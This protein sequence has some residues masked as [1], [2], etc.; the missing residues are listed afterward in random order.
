MMPL[1]L[2]LALAPADL[3]TVDIQGD[4]DFLSIQAAVDGAA[5]GDTI[6]VHVPDDP[7]Q[8]LAGFRITGKSLTVSSV[9]GAPV[10]D[11]LYPEARQL[12]GPVSIQGLGQDQVVVLTGLHFNAPSSLVGNG[13]HAPGL[14]VT[15]CAGSVRVEDC[16]IRGPKASQALV[17][18]L[19]AVS[20]LDLTVVDCIVAG[21]WQGGGTSGGAIRLSASRA[22]FYQSTIDGFDGLTVTGYDGLIRGGDGGFGIVL[23]ER[24]FAWIG[25]C[26]VRGG[27]GGRA[28]CHI[29]CDTEGGDGGVGVDCQPASVCMILD[30]PVAGGAGGAAGGGGTNVPGQDASSTQGLPFLVPGAQRRMEVPGTVRGNELATVRIVGVPGERATIQIGTLGGLRFLGW[31]W[32]VYLQRTPLAA[33]IVDL[34]IIPASGEITGSVS[35]PSVGDDE[36][37]TF[38]LQGVCRAVPNR[39][40]LTPVV[41][42][43]VHGEGLPSILPGERVYVDS[44]S[45]PGGNG[46]SWQLARSNLRAALRAAPVGPAEDPVEIWIREGRY[47]AAAPGGSVDAFFPLRDG[48]DLYGGFAGDELSLGERSPREHVTLIDADLNGDDTASGNRD[49][50]ATSLFVAGL[51]FDEQAY[52]DSVRL[53][54]MTLRGTREGPAVALS[55]SAVFH[56]VIFH[57]NH[58][59][60]NADAGAICH[61][62]VPTPLHQQTRIVVSRCMFAGNDGLFGGAIFMEMTPWEMFNPGSQSP[63][64]VR[65]EGSIFVGNHSTV[66]SASFTRRP[67]GGVSIFDNVSGTPTVTVASNTFYRNTVSAVFAGTALGYNG[68]NSTTTLGTITNNIFWENFNLASTVH[69]E[70]RGFDVFGDVLRANCFTNPPGSGLG[71]DNTTDPP[72]F[73]NPLGADGISGT[74]DDDLTLAGSSLL[75]DRGGSEFIPTSMTVDYAGNPRVVDDPNAPNTGTGGP[76]HVDIGAYERQ[77]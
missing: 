24:S 25:G 14:W 7:K 36:V 71:I 64:D 3:H 63:P 11:A 59:G 75:V 37:R 39:F 20:A 41:A 35:L 77:Q 72:T 28:V 10:R 6:L 66:P 31:E 27:D 45:A 21:S 1:A 34:G 44:A 23:A 13:A 50:N 38:F 48:V 2:L 60:S 51:S 33:D 73:T 19:E 69:N 18:A 74:I 9:G 46:R 70:I 26:S 4:G 40:R 29:I 62:Q 42:V 32:G 55:G 76:P 58:G 5:D 67:G 68:F 47:T 30:S 43:T 61:G 22:A 49:D 12:V 53:D 52:L 57:D 8:L 65:I 16:T 54:G 56:D 17:P 15:D